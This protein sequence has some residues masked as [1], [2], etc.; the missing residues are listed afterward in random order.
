M[1]FKQDGI[2]GDRKVCD[3]S[4]YHLTDISVTIYMPKYY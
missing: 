3:L 1:A 2:V 4:H